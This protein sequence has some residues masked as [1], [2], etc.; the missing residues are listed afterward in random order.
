[1]TRC[2]RQAAW[3]LALCCAVASL[4]ASEE[5]EL[6]AV[7]GEGIRYAIELPKVLPPA[8]TTDP[9][10]QLGLFLCFHEH[11]G[12]AGDEIPTVAHAL[13]RLKLAP[14]YILIGVF[15]AAHGYSRQDHAHT[16]E[17]LAWAK[18]TYAINPRRVYAFGRGEGATM[19]A[20]FALEHPDLVACAITYSWGFR[21]MPAAADPLRDLPSL[22]VVLGQKD[23]PTHLAMV[24]DTYARAK[25]HGYQ[26]IYREFPSGGGSVDPATNDDAVLWATLSR[27]KVLPLAERE[28]AL[29]RPLSAAD[30]AHPVPASAGLFTNVTLVGGPQAGALLVPLL[31]GKDDAARLLAAHAAEHAMLGEDALT[32]IAAL[33]GERGPALRKAALAAL[34]ANVAWGSPVAK[35]ALAAFA[36]SA[37][38]ATTGKPAD[39]AE[40]A[41]AIAAIGQ[42]LALQITG[43]QQDVALFK[44]LVDLLDDDSAVVRAQAFAV[45]KPLQAGDYHPEAGKAARAP[46][47]VAWQKWLAEVA[48]KEPAGPAE[49]A[50]AK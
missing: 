12:K 30:A 46:T 48:I 6:K 22:Y 29:L 20:E 49:A 10:R 50:P 17:L 44:T 36:S 4:G 2:G 13:E 38:N 7:G 21:A 18:R 5:A 34:G 42:G 39:P 28:A 8:A 23:I 40:R 15:Q 9:A 25:A 32:A 35:R 27:N 26:L 14:G 24:R 1:M 45:L 11:G 33:L 31:G 41:L 37:V 43:H 47:L 3:A 19:A 16:V